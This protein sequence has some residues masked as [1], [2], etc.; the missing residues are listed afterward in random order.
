MLAL[1]GPPASGKTSVALAASARLRAPVLGFGDFVRAE[2][3]GRGLRDDRGTLQDVGERLHAELGGMGLCRAVLG[4]AGLTAGTWPVIWDGVRHVD[5]AAALRSLYPVPVLLVVLRPP[6]SA[7]RTRFRREVRSDEQLAE[8]ERHATEAELADLERE[9]NFV[10]RA[11]SI[12]VAVDVVLHL[13]D[14]RR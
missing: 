9:A 5:V 2:A 3:R 10:C 7:R 13:T 14:A 1:A 6:E 12:D 4:H 8:F 11:S